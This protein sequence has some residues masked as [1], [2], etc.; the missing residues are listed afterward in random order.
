MPGSFRLNA[1][2][3]TIDCTKSWDFEVMMK[4]PELDTTSRLEGG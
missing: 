4:I 1:E 3:R 2:M